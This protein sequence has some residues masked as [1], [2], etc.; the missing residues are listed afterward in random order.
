MELFL[1]G[2]YRTLVVKLYGELD[3]HAAQRVRESVDRE[4]LKSGAVNVAFDFENVTFMD[5]SGIGV[6]MGRCKITK[7]L[8]GSVI[9]YSAPEEVKRIITMAGIDKIV[10]LSEDIEQGVKEAALNV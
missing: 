1:W 8:G 4:L 9:I 6:I 10:T 2:K 7:S 5:S 3:H